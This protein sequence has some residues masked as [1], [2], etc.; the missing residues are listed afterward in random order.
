MQSP[1][2]LF[3]PSKGKSVPLPVPLQSA[4]WHTFPAFSAQHFQILCHLIKV[5]SC[6]TG[7]VHSVCCVNIAPWV[8]VCAGFQMT[9]CLDTV[10]FVFS[11]VQGRS[12]AVQIT[13]TVSITSG[14]WPWCLKTAQA[15]HGWAT[16]AY[17]PA[18][19]LGVLELN[20]TFLQ[21]NVR[22]STAVYFFFLCFCVVFFFLTL[23]LKSV[24]TRFLGNYSFLSVL[25][26]TDALQE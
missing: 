11:T 1:V 8:C 2:M 9:T 23:Q 21:R 22:F 6:V 26:E 5:C 19:I 10:I 13:D 25:S 16:E 14:C 18:G 3:F 7:H 15:I 17:F 12:L 24:L 20:I 4:L